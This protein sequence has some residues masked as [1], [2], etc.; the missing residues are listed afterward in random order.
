MLAAAE[1]QTPEQL[2][3][4]VRQHQDELAG[5]DD[6]AKRLERQQKARTA[7]F[8]EQDD[9]MWRLFALFDPITAQGIRAA[10]NHKTDMAWHAT[11]GPMPSPSC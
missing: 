4:T 6:G 7:S 2:R 10:L 1:A 8:S 9:G 3:R 11:A 5:D